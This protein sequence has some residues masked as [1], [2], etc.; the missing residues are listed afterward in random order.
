MAQI[1]FEPLD[2]PIIEQ[3]QFGDDMNRWITNIVDII[4]ANFTTVSNAL[5]SLIAVGQID[6]GGSGAGPI[7]V[8]VAGLNSSNFVNVTLISSSNSVSVALVTAI[9]NGFNITFS[10]D[11]GASAVIAYQAFT[12]KMV[13]KNLLLAAG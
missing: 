4:N 13:L 9:T 8:T 7:T 12:L 1:N 5:V 10:A 11:P 2:P 3:T 6:V